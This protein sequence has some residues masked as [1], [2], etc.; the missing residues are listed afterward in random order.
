MC[1]AE[2]GRHQPLLDIDP[3]T[4]R[5]EI[6]RP[7]HRTIDPDDRFRLAQAGGGPFGPA[8]R[9]MGGYLALPVGWRNEPGNVTAREWVGL[10]Y[11]QVGALAPKRPKSR[12]ARQKS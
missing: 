6:R 11:R 3:D 10:A 12:K 5:A 8:E 7:P 1:L 9:P 2:L 4:A